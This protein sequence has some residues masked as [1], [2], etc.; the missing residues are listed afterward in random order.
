MISSVNIGL[1]SIGS[2]FN[3]DGVS[4]N[5]VPTSFVLTSAVLLL[6]FGRISDIY[7]KKKVYSA[8]MAIYTVASFF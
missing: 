7:G 8:G 5:W 1:P 2:E 6:P 4:L 3:V